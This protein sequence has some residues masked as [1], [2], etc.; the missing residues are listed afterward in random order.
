MLLK[1]AIF[2]RLVG[3]NQDPTI[4]IYQTASGTPRP[5]V[6][7]RKRRNNQS[8]LGTSIKTH[9]HENNCCVSLCTEI[10]GRGGGWYKGAPFVG[11]WWNKKRAHM[12]SSQ[13]NPHHGVQSADSWWSNNGAQ[14]TLP[15]VIHVQQC[16][17]R[18][19]NNLYLASAPQRGYTFTSLKQSHTGTWQNT[20]ST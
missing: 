10:E 11:W 1:N 16:C 3:P 5:L 14:Q 13:L 8:S 20:A 15:L 7:S 2:I 4:R 6:P 18:E 9:S 12:S 17:W 19:E